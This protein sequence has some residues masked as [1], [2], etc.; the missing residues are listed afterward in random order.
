M[1]HLH[2]LGEGQ[3]ASTVLV[4][5]AAKGTSNPPVLL[6]RQGYKPLVA[7]AHALTTSAPHD[8][9][10]LPQCHLHPNLS[11]ALMMTHQPLPHLHYRQIS[12]GGEVVAAPPV[13]ALSSIRFGS[14]TQEHI[15]TSKELKPAH[16]H[17]GAHVKLAIVGSA[18]ALLKDSSRCNLA[19]F[20]SMT[21]QS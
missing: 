18:S 20:C 6:T 3:L 7:H 21:A 17:Q 8:P 1:T 2:V 9:L 4:L 10:T 15:V 13:L 5:H 12:A 14:S 11:Q 16:R 19:A